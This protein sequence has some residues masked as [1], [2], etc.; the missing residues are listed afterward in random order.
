MNTNLQA[1][2]SNSTHTD[3]STPWGR[4]PSSYQMGGLRGSQHQFGYAT[5]K[6]ST[7]L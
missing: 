1:C 5:G 6:Y 3:H 4:A 2:L 7:I